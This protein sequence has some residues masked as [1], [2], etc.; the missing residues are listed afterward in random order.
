M[1]GAQVHSTSGAA[2]EAAQAAA[3]QAEAALMAAKEKAAQTAS[4]VCPYMWQRGF[5]CLFVW[6]TTA[7]RFCSCHFYIY[8]IPSQ[9]SLSIAGPRKSTACL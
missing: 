7:G 4:Q 8:S 1:H 5:L 2:R 9:V 6:D 3:A